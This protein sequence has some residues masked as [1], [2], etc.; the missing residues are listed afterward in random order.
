MTRTYNEEWINAITLLY[1]LFLLCQ[2]SVK[3]NVI[4]PI[5]VI[6]TVRLSNNNNMCFS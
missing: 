1:F 3:V 5:S 2:C 4:L 6:E